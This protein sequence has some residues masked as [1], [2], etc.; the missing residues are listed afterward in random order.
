MARCR[1]TP[2]PPDARVDGEFALNEFARL[3]ADDLQFLRL[4]V[5]LEGRIR[6]MESALGVSYPTI[7]ARIAAL[8]RTLFDVAP[9]ASDEG[10]TSPADAPADD[11]GVQRI[12]EQL[13][14]GTISPALAK[15]LLRKR[16]DQ[17]P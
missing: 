12:L 15:E 13:E 16:Q 5:H 14:Q 17:V 7:K 3:S 8:K 4:F 10:Q 6:D 2:A 11:D 9:P 1:T